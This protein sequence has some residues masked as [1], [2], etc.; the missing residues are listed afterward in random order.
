MKAEENNMT[1]SFAVVI[2]NEDHRQK[3]F[4]FE[5]PNW[6]LKKGDNV[7]V[8][9]VLGET[10]GKVIAVKN[11]AH[12]EDIDFINALNRDRRIKRVLAKFEITYNKFDGYYKKHDE[13]MAAEQKAREEALAKKAAEEAEEANEE[14][15]E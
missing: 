15:T 11:Y 3:P 10:E 6:E 7:I 13:K 5:C 12:E 9:T 1:T 2:L 14:V 4:I 8:E